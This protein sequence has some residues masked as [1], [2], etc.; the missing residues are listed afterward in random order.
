VTLTARDKVLAVVLPALLV[1]IGYATYG[2]SMWRDKFS[3][4]EKAL[5]D[6]RGRLPSPKVE[7]ERLAK[8]SAANREMADENDTV[9]TFRE[10][11]PRLAAEIEE[12]KGR[13]QAAKKTLAGTEHQAALARMEADHFAA[14]KQADADHKAALARVWLTGD[15]PGGDRTGRIEQLN[16]VLVRYDLR[17]VD[18]T[19]E[20]TLE[21]LPPRLQAVVKAA[22]AVD[23][24]TPPR[25][26]QI[27]LRGKYA[28]VAAA[29]DSIARGDAWAVPLALTM[30]P[31]GDESGL[32]D[33]TL[34]VWV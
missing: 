5:A 33:W 31:A 26:R 8:L 29:L 20:V 17:I 16:K 19:D 21:P 13:L 15:G 32:L 11:Q 23:G 4:A 10:Q 25:L 30:K 27:K 24:N 28:A 3:A 34:T 9:K 1:F 14:E 2:M 6:T 12:E 18:A 22:A 7:S